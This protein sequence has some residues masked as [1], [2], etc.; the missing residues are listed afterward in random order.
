VKRGELWVA[1]GGGDYTG[2]APACRHRAGRPFRGHRFR[3]RL[4]PDQRSDRCPAVSHPAFADREERTACTMDSA[5]HRF[6]RQ[7]HHC[8]PGA[9]GPADRL[10][11]RHRHATDRPGDACILGYRP[12]M[13][14]RLPRG[15]AGRDRAE[16]S[17]L[18]A[19]HPGAGQ[20]LCLL[21]SSRRFTVRSPG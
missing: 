16:K 15:V 13:R 1:A 9:P 11:L 19:R 6:D 5:S 17:A 18:T 10:P 21:Q 7:D 2:Q 14:V 8:P 4:R 20:G 12:I 3:D